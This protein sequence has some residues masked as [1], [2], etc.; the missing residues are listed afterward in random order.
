MCHCFPMELGRKYFSGG[1]VAPNAKCYQ[2]LR[3]IWR[4]KV[5][6]EQP[7][8]TLYKWKPLAELKISAFQQF[9]LLQAIFA[10]PAGL[11]VSCK[12]ILNDEPLLNRCGEMV[13]F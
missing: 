5:F 8:T 7:Y 12:T 4:K 2:L 3:A 9:C 11:L 13:F 6:S 1:S 10:G